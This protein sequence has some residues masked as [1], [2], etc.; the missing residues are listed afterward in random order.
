MMGGSGCSTFSF[1]GIYTVCTPA[2]PASFRVFMSD[3]WKRSSG[4][5]MAYFQK[6]AYVA[7][8]MHKVG[9]VRALR[10]RKVA[11]VLHRGAVVSPSSCSLDNEG[12]GGAT[13]AQQNI[14]GKAVLAQIFPK[15]KPPL[16]RHHRQN[17][18]V[19]GKKKT[20]D[21]TRSQ[22]CAKPHVLNGGNTAVSP[23]EFFARDWNGVVRTSARTKKVNI[24][25]GA[26]VVVSSERRNVHNGCSHVGGRAHRRKD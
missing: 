17:L 7:C 2:R 12:E 13:A 8:T 9:N 25:S 14:F 6:Q 1:R 21:K 26:T 5:G 11:L 18:L 10:Y 16:G 22:P 20:C 23:H 15:T 3:G 4:G 24:I 19:V